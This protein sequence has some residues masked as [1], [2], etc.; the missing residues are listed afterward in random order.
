LRNHVM[1]RGSAVVNLKESGDEDHENRENVSSRR[2]APFVPSPR[3]PILLI[4]ERVINWWVSCEL[5]SWEE[6]HPIKL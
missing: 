5:L 3:W 4:Q 6:V 2:A 1:G